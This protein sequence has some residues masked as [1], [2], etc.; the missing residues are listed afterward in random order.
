[1]K[2]NAT[3]SQIFFFFASQ[4]LS[5]EAFTNQKFKIE[6]EWASDQTRMSA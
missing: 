6:L 2:F 4:I 3:A 5:N 1:M